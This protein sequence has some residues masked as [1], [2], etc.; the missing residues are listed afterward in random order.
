MASLD[1]R[2]KLILQAIV[3]DYIKNAEPVGSRSIAKKT[4][5]N[6]SAATIRNEMCDLEDMGM[7]IQP[8]TSAGRI[9]SNAGFRFYVDNLMHRY[10]MTALEIKRLRAAMMNNFR[11]LDNIIKGVSSA[12]SSITSLP[13]FAMLPMNKYGNIKNVKLADVDGRTI[14]VIVSDSSGLI[15]NKLL[16]LRNTVTPEEVAE[17]N[18]VINENISGLDLDGFISLDNVMGIKDAVGENVEI[19]SSV[20]EL[21]YEAQ[22][23][24]ES[25][26]VVVEGTSNILWYPEYNDVE[27]IKN[28]LEFFDDENVLGE[29]VDAVQF[30]GDG[31]VDIFIGDELPL[32]QLKENSVVVSQYQVGEDLVGIVG[33][34]GPQRMDYAKVVSG[35]K[36]FSEN[37]GQMLSSRFRPDDDE[38]FDYNGGKR[39]WLKVKSKEENQ[40]ETMDNKESKIEEC[41]EDQKQQ[42]ESTETPVQETENPENNEEETLAQK[43]EEAKDRFLRKVAEFDNFKKRTAKEKT[44]NFSLGICEAVEKLL[45][46]LD[47]LDRAIVAAESNDDKEALLEGIKMVR[48]QFC[49]ALSGIGVSEIEAVG[50]EFD[51]DKHNAVMMED[52][53]LPSN[54]V[55]EEFA[56]GYAYNRDDNVKVIRHS[57]VKVSN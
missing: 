57:M 13:T 6:L 33:V 17:L 2:K 54:T 25:K 46:V 48:K 45:P 56:K 19:L 27:K 38:N 40:Q 39:G 43:L 35:I 22:R 53:D 1:D 10:Q 37:L 16:R 36:F 42:D 31:G 23:E 51:P 7:L 29:I 18:R 55:I 11:E 32:P 49:E 28:I 20:L 9:P 3:E 44:E 4:S 15:K 50:K 21:I 41:M 52:S 30:E 26:Q 12:F 34:I 8:H 24:I 47:N 5:L 14:M